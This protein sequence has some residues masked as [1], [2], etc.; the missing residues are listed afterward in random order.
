MFVNVMVQVLHMGFTLDRFVHG[1]SSL[2]D[3]DTVYNATR[4]TDI[5]ERDVV[6]GDWKSQSYIF[7]YE[8]GI[9]PCYIGTER[10]PWADE[11]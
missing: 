9:R 5:R 4:S 10:D 2:Y 8:N 11:R 6:K 7:A 3:T 1:K